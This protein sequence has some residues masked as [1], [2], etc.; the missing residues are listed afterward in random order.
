MGSR[1]AAAR[2]PVCSLALIRGE[3]ESGKDLKRRLDMYLDHIETFGAQRRK[4]LMHAGEHTE[5]SHYLLFDYST[6]AEALGEE[7]VKGVPR[8]LVRKAKQTILDQLRGCQN[9][10]GSFIDNPLIGPDTG[11]GL[12]LLCLFDLSRL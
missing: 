5:G 12:A 7:S 4:A 6:A 9:L 10:N 3:R 2:G 8:K 11:T 1:R